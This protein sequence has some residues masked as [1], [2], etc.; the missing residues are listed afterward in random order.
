M[1]YLPLIIV[2]FIMFLIGF[3]YL[4]QGPPYVPSNDEVTKQIVLKIQKMKPS[5][6]LELGSGDGKV[7]IALA[8]QGFNV[9]G[10]ELNPLLVLRS[11]RMIKSL[12][13]ENKAEIKWANLWTFNTS[14]YKIIVIYLI[15]HIMPRLE[16]KLLKEHNNDTTV[17]SNYCEFPNLKP[18]LREN[19]LKI[20][21]V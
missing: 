10:V 19:R 8:Q 18:V 3:I 2:S 15:N 11:K 1:L 21:K 20:Y 17:L 4:L 7:V 16:K 9:V 6:I 13:L 12:G 5:T 14:N